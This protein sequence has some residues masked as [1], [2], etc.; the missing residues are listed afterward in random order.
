MTDH[1]F[2]Q[3][4]HFLAKNRIAGMFQAKENVAAGGLIARGLNLPSSQKT[5]KPRLAAGLF[6][7]R[8]PMASVRRLA[9][10]V[11]VACCSAK[12]RRNERSPF[13]TDRPQD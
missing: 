6:F 5:L 13:G 8:A 2:G 3:I 4:I 7:M 11:R 9:G 1:Q 12:G 10:T